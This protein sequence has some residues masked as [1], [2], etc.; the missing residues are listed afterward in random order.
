MFR[1]RASS[2]GPGGVF[3]HGQPVATP[4]HRRRGRRRRAAKVVHIARP[5]PRR[6]ARLVGVPDDERPGAGSARR[7][8]VIGAVMVAAVSLTL[9]GLLGRVLQLQLS[10]SERIAAMIDDPQSTAA[11]VARRGTI[12]DRHGRPLAVTRMG[13]RLWVDPLRIDERVT[14]SERVGYGLGY[15]PVEL[16]MRMFNRESRRYV[17]LDPRMDDEQVARFKALEQPIPGLAIEPTPVRDYPQ[18]GVAAQV[19]G[20]ARV[21]GKG[22]EGVERVRDDTLSPQPG[23]VQITRDAR[24]RPLWLYT[25]GYEPQTRGRDVTLTIDVVVQQ[26]A[27]KHLAETVQK[28]NAKSGELVVMD[29][30]TGQLLAVASYPGYDPNAFSDA[31]PETRRNRVVTDAFEPGSIFKPIVWA[32]L[33]ETG[34]I[35]P[36]ERVDCTDSGFWVTPYRRRLRD[37]HGHGTITWRRVLV[38]SSNI[39]MAKGAERVSIRELHDMV[40]RFGFGEETGSGMPGEIPGLVNAFRH[41]NKYSQSSI[42]MGQ[43]IGVTAIQMIR[44]FA[45]IANDGRL[46]TPTIELNPSAEHASAGGSG[47]QVLRPDVAALTRRVLRETVTDGTGR[48]AN[49]DLYPIFGKTGTAQLPDFVNGGYHQDRYVSSFVG[50]APVERPR[51][52]VGCFIHEPDRS[53][54]H[55]GGIV[56]A[57]AVK[58]VIEE[59]LIYLGE[60]APQEPEMIGGPLVMTDEDAFE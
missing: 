2:P 43:E 54:G 29:P 45:V 6:H 31:A 40:R 39:G 14:F 44:A 7:V 48:K 58:A 51:L 53:I 32:A 50:G 10:P 35:G 9:V 12:R 21:D 18:G 46:V 30:Q 25:A 57:P 20:F 22:A 16:E 42:P 47:T 5:C 60:P 17:L 55:Y 23:A 15:N 1:R 24:R 38:E 4:P 8:Y 11:L 3:P 36:E 33:T 41:W 37:A 34:V 59:S 28:Y 19:V 13:Y 26:I 27:E 56:S 52:V 49:S